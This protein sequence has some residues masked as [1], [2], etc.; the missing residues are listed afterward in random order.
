[1]QSRRHFYIYSH[2]YRFAHPTH[3]PTLSSGMLQAW[4]MDDDTLIGK[5]TTL[6][7]VHRPLRPMP[8][9]EINLQKFQLWN[10]QAILTED[11]PVPLFGYFWTLR[12]KWFREVPLGSDDSI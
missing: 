10:P 7:E 3:A 5:F 6:L 1:M 8:D 11:Y 12:A 9:T 2:C 4:Y